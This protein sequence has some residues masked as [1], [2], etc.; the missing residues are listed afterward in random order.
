MPDPAQFRDAA[1]RLREAL[2]GTTKEQGSVMFLDGTDFWEQ[3]RR[4]P[5]LG[6]SRID[7]GPRGRRSKVEPVT[8]FGHD[9]L[10]GRSFD[11]AQAM[12]GALEEAGRGADAG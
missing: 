9:L 3:R 8:L 11:T 1:R 12:L 5:Q 7:R 2:E 10:P 4:W 6:V